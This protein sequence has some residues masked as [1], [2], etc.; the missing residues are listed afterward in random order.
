MVRV[1]VCLQVFCPSPLMRTVICTSG[2]PIYY[3]MANTA[4]FAWQLDTASEQNKTFIWNA[5]CIATSPVSIDSQPIESPRPQSDTTGI[6][7]APNIVDAIFSRI[8]QSA[9]F[10]A[11]VTFVGNSE[12]GKK[13]FPN[14]N[15]MIELGYA[16]KSIGWERTILVMNS[17]YGGAK[18]LPFDILQHRWPIEYRLT[19]RTLVGDK[20]FA[21]LTN[22]LSSAIIDC[23]CHDLERANEM[24]KVMDTGTIDFI[25]H[26]RSKAFIEMCLPQRTVGDFLGN[27]ESVLATRRLVEIGAI[28]IVD[29]PHMGFAWTYDGRKMIDLLER[30]HSGVLKLFETWTVDSNSK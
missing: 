21:S 8:R 17:A 30:K 3:C 10:V 16:A 26:N 19:D 25:A 2:L 13:R 18:H 23:A 5:L 22:A 6:P 14:P 7:G 20:R 9:I 28:E 27:T 29:T 11:D 1:L 4:F 12:D 15:V 24:A